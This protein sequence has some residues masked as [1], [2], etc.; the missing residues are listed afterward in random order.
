[1]GED[2]QQHAQHFREGSV[3]HPREQDLILGSYARHLGD[4]HLARQELNADVLAEDTHLFAF[5]Q[6]RSA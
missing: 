4:Q 6:P 1:L 3:V 2:E 5:C